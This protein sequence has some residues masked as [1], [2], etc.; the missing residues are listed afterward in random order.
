M[1]S[2]EHPFWYRYTQGIRQDPQNEKMT[3][4]EVVENMKQ[5]DYS[6]QYLDYPE[7]NNS[8]ATCRGAHDHLHM[9]VSQG[10]CAPQSSTFL[11]VVSAS[12]GIYLSESNSE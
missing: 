12:T 11:I 2:T 1:V 9:G 5:R 3:A 4:Q 8:D 7:E 10:L 6:D